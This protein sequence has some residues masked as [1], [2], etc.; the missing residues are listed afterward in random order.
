MELT[1]WLDT[2]EE[3]AEFF[4]SVVTV[5]EIEPGIMVLERKGATAKASDLRR[6]MIGP[7]STYDDRIM[8]IDPAVATVS[9]QLEAQAIAAGHSPGM[10]D[11]RIAGTAKAHNLTVVTLNARHFEPFG[12]DLMSAPV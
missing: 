4:L 3:T 6:W 1:Y 8:L 7:F 12:I 2:A 9:G 5:H 10:T 11:A